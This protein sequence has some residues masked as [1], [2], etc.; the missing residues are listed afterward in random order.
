M[1]IQSS[2]HCWPMGLL[3]YVLSSV[4][5]DTLPMCFA[6]IQHIDAISMLAEPIQRVPCFANRKT[7]IESSGTR[8][9][10]HLHITHTHVRQAHTQTVSR[11]LC[12]ALLMEPVLL[13]LMMEGPVQVKQHPLWC[14]CRLSAPT[15][16][17][18]RAEKRQRGMFKSHWWAGKK[19]CYGSSLWI[20][21]RLHSKETRIL[22]PDYILLMHYWAQERFH[23][24]CLYFDALI[25]CSF[26]WMVHQASLLSL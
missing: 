1:G 21:V 2:R 7:S 16:H 10:T 24:M 4:K 20:R 25:Q 18:C 5:Y 12:A 6:L 13:V 9:R 11:D 15:W 22:T 3:V 8:T 17:Q 19:K 23:K 26:V 14:F